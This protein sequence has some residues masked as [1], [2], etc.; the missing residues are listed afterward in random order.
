MIADLIEREGL[1]GADVA[2]I[3]DGKVEIALGRAAGARTVGLASDEAQRHG[4]N[5]VKRER[6]I[7]AGA[8]VIAGDFLDMDELLVFLGLCASIHC[9]R[10]GFL[11]YRRGMPRDSTNLLHG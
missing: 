10:R 2:V 6:L 5:P 11:K 4:V 7:R 8:D 1:R 3:G 9:I